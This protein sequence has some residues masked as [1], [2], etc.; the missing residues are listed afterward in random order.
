[1]PSACVIVL[2]AVGAG[3][4]PDADQYGDEGSNTLGNVAQGGRRPRPAEPRGARAR[5][6]RAARGLPAAAGRAGRRRPAARA[7]EGQGHDDRSLGADG[8]R[9]GD[10]V[11]DLSARLP[12]R[13]DRPVHAPHRPRRDRQQA[14]VGD[15]DHPGARRGAPAH[16]QVDRLHV[17]RLGLPDRRARGDGAARGAVRG[18][19]RRARAPDRQARRRARDRAAVRRRARQLRADA[20]PPRLLAR[21]APA[22]LPDADPRGRREGAT[23]SARSATSSPAATSTSR[24]RRSRTSRGSSRRSSCCGSSTTASSS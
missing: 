9:H 15:G 14:G 18:V 20:E 22:E 19:P 2:D 6:R 5:Q 3:A 11:P 1:M 21:A 4:L 8:R 13:R 17:R 12:A 7:L 16:G 10:G 24:T 23:A